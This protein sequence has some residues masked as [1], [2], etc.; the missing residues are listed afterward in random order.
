MSILWDSGHETIW[1]RWAGKRPTHDPP[2]LP[3]TLLSGLF[4]RLISKSLSCKLFSDTPVPP[5]P[6]WEAGEVPPCQSA[7]TGIHTPTAATMP[8]AGLEHTL[9]MC[10]IA[11]KFR[12][13]RAFSES[14]PVASPHRHTHAPPLLPCKLTGWANAPGFLQRHLQTLRY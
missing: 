1:E 8:V 3:A 13:V 7:G 11:E 5:R 10:Q 14:E 12:Y 4:H 9:H 2:W 6:Y